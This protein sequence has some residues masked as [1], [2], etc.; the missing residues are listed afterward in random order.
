LELIKNP[1]KFT[2]ATSYGAAGYVKNIKFN[3]DTGEIITPQKLL[4]WLSHDT[5]CYRHSYFGCTCKTSIAAY[6]EWWQYI[7]HYGQ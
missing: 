1:G 7:F 5:F 2:R 6:Y 4:A 3:K